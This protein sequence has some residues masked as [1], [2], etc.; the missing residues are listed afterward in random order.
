MKDKVIGKYKNYEITAKD[1][2]GDIEIVLEEYY[3]LSDYMINFSDADEFIND[4]LIN[5]NIGNILE[6][7]IYVLK[8]LK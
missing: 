1:L 5:D 8:H 4:L 3:T 6:N 7:I 2:I